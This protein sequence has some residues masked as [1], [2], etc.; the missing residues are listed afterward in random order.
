MHQNYKLDIQNYEK[1]KEEKGM[2]VNGIIKTN[3]HVPRSL[4]SGVT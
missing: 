3:R 1:E 2:Q 4:S